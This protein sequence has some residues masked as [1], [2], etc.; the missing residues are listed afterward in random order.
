MSAAEQNTNNTEEAGKGEADKEELDKK[1]VKV[2]ESVHPTSAPLEALTELY[3]R[4]PG[5]RHLY[6]MNQSECISLIE[7]LE[8]LLKHYLSEFG[9]S[10]LSKPRDYSGHQHSEDSE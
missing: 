6:H 4:I 10:A 7:H 3:W 8:C 5:Y 1:E 9:E 2:E